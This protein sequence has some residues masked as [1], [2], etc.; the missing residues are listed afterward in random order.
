MKGKGTVQHFC[1]YTSLLAY[2]ESEEKIII[3]LYYYY[4]IFYSV[5]PV[6]R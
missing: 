1:E 6:Q 2:A 3:I 4:Y 5:C